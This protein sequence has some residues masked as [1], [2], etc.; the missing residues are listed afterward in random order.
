MIN[1]TVYV[2]LCVSVCCYL[3]RALS[4]PTA[5]VAHWFQQF[6]SMNKAAAAAR[7]RACTKSDRARIHN[8]L[9][10]WGDD[11]SGES[12]YIHIYLYSNNVIVCV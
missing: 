9:G 11:R 2:C 1:N 3:Q 8:F 5:L 7:V 10:D 4:V 12:E 6:P